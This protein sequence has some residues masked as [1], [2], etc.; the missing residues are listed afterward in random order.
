MSNSKPNWKRILE[1]VAALATMIA[2]FIGGQAAAQNGYIDI[3]QKY[4]QV[5]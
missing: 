5:K 4:E 2:S 1:L 3:F